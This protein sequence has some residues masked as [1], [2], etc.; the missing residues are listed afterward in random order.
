MSMEIIFLGTAGSVPTKTRNVSSIVVRYQGDYI[1]V[2]V[3]EG[4]QRQA[5]LS[6]VGLRKNMKIFITHMHGDHVL[7]LIPMLQT[8]CML[9]RTEPLQIYG[10]RGIRR[11]ITE[12]MRMLNIRPTYPLVINYLSDGRVFDFGEYVV[13]VARNEHDRYS[14]ALCIEEKPRPGRFDPEKAER[15]GI[16]KHL[17]RLLK[18]GRTVTL[19]DGRVVDYRRYV[20]PPLRGRKV[21]I[22]GDTRPCRRIVSLARDADVLI[23]DATFASDRAERGVE[24]GHSTAE[25]AAIVAREANVKVLILTHFSARYENVDRLVREAR[26]IFPAT[27]A[28]EDFMRVEVPPS[29][30]PIRTW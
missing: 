26:R 6:G 28:A 12:N 18:Q 17:W 15:D 22:S 13:K 4:T 7:G 29:R 21:V 11:F 2:D 10:P 1:F 19:E 27:F 8:M 9:R 23:H 25:E 24:T 20:S 3:G 30:R 5:M 14:Y 16:P